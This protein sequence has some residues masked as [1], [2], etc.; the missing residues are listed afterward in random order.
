MY[1]V[2][3]HI[4]KDTGLP[5]YVGKGHGLRCENVRGRSIYWTNV[6][7][8]HDWYFDIIAEFPTETEAFECEKAVIRFFG[9]RDIGTGILVNLTDGGEGNA[10]TIFTEE[11]LRNMSNGRKGKPVSEETRRK[12][13]EA[14]KKRKGKV[15]CSEEKKAKLR[16]SC[17]VGT[18]NKWKDKE[19]REKVSE[20][21][22]GIRYMNRKSPVLHVT[23]NGVIRGTAL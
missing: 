7:R 16:E 15:K 14:A 13:S 20:G 18:L 12:Q 10:G 9:R 21:H 8:K 1:Y 19:F 22:K 4:E 11:R 17:R 3:L 5:F 2:Y 23:K 6:A